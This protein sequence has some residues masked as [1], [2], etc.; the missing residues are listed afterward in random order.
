MSSAYATLGEANAY[1]QTRLHSGLWIE[2]PQNERE[3]ALVEATR[4]ID[5]LNFNGSKAAVGQELEFPRGSDSVVPNDIKIASYEIAFSILDGVDA[6][7]ELKNL[8]I[9]SQGYASVR[10]TYDRSLA[11]E[12]YSVGIPSSRAWQLLR[13]FVRDINSVRLSRV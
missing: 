6:E 11:V 13:P 7:V 10:T 2:M 1:F 4:I 5:R 3:I 9:V 12:H 8:S